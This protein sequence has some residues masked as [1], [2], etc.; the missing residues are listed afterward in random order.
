MQPH[1]AVVH[2][3]FMQLN[4]LW[5]GEGIIPS[6]FDDIYTRQSEALDSSVAFQFLLHYVSLLPSNSQQCPAS[7]AKAQLKIGQLQYHFNLTCTK[8][9]N[10]QL[11]ISVW[12]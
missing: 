11:T 9:I 4:Q 2:G 6:D 3:L 5:Q 7:E 12:S 1:L 8:I 10:L